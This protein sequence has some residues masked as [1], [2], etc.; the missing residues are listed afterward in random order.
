GRERLTI[1][2]LTKNEVGKLPQCLDSITWADEIVV[3]DGQSTDGTQAVARAYGATVIERPF[4]GSFAQERNA[5]LA[6]STGDWV[7][8]MDADE[9]VSPELRTAIER[10]LVE[11]SPHA[12]LKVRRRNYFLGHQM[13]YGGWYHYNVA[14]FRRTLVRY[15]GLVHERLTIDGTTGV[16]EADLLHRPFSSFE[17]FIDRQNRY[18]TLQA[19][20]FLQEDRGSSIRLMHEVRVRP[21]KLWWK[22][23]VKKQGFREGF[24]GVSFS[25]LFAW[26]HFLKWAKYWEMKH[27]REARG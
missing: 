17:Q 8:Q 6:V 4:S 25:I 5:G 14:L 23:Y 7:L 18:T 24:Y 1:L 13:R 2:L 11:G 16:L 9:T 10:L 15:E 22:L 19:R 27:V 20:E 21:I 26:V 12:A 3:V